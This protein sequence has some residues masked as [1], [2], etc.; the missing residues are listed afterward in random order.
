MSDIFSLAGRTALV[1]GA[2]RGL[3]FAM[4][5]ALAR[6]GAHVV[7]NGRDPATL[8]ARARELTEAGLKASIAAFEATDEAAARD[9]IA[10]IEKAHGGLD[11]LIAN[12]GTNV[13]KPVLEMTT[14]EWRRVVDVNLT[15]C[16]TLARDAAKGMVKRGWGRI[17][18]TGSILSVL[19]RATVPAYVAS[20]HGVGGL[21]RSMGAELGRLGV[22]VNAIGPGYIRTDL[23]KP[24][25]EDAT[26][27]AWLVTRTPLGRWG[28]PDEVAG[29]AV[30]LASDAASYVNGHL[31]MVDGGHTANA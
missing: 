17:I 18:F 8:T 7:L 4:A 31:L 15:A 6:A 23:T 2:S 10:A 12:A 20:K 9:A 21:A 14:E 13:R 27:C 1:T 30:F 19:G 26:F 11:I 24:L 22:T 28:E 29:A 3:G 5:R 25:T 16:F